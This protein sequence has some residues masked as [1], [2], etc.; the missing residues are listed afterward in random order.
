MKDKA[1]LDDILSSPDSIPAA[2]G[3]DYKVE[4]DRYRNP[5]NT[6]SNENFTLKE[7]NSNLRIEL[8]TKNELDKLIVPSSNKAFTFMSCY[9]GGVAVFLFLDGVSTNTFD[10]PDSVLNFLV[11]ST[12]VTVVGLVGMVLTGVF[13]GARSTRNNSK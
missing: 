9:S 2:S 4:D 7:E 1:V 6:V 13:V 11:G 3:T 12:A 10:L 5:F 8:N